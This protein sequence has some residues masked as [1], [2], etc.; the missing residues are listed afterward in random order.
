MA[1]AWTRTISLS[2]IPMRIA[3]RPP[4]ARIAH[5]D[6]A[7]R[8]GNRP[9]ASELAQQLEVAPRTVHRD[10][11]FLR[12]RLKAPLVFDPVCNGYRYDDAGYQLPFFRLT[13]GELLAVFLAERLLQQY[14][15]TPYA[16]ALA[17][18]F[19]RMISVLPDQVTIDLSHLGEAFSFRQQTADPGDAER[20]IRLSQAVRESN[21]LEIVYWTASRDATQSRVVDPYHLVSVDGDW[22]LV[23]YCH[24]REDVRMFSPARIRELRETGVHFDRPADFNI[25][26]YLDTGFRKIRGT[27]PLQTVRLRFTPKAARYIREKTWH[28]T[29]Q[30]RD[31][32]DGGLILTL[33][34]NH[35]LEIKR[36]VLSHGAECQVLQP[37]ELR[38]EIR[39]ELQC[40]LEVYE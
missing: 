31:E 10:I 40:S 16:T 20:F 4:L 25:A 33:K 11:Q 7:I 27:G 30:V 12:D 38:K 24:F 21:Q 18:A 28:P 35:M 5:I 1:G 23:G 37:A 34:V 32:K 17:T 13:E 8:A 19:Q 6:Q 9:N 14:H 39:E 22:F 3:S 15:G 2:L 26:A 29:Q 36:W